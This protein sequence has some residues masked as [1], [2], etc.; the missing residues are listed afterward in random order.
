MFLR[1]LGAARILPAVHGFP[2]NLRGI[3]RQL[4]LK[5]CV[6]EPV[7]AVLR[8]N[9]FPVPLES[10]SSASSAKRL[11]VFASNPITS[12]GQTKV[13][14]T[15]WAWAVTQL[16]SLYWVGEITSNTVPRVVVINSWVLPGVA[17]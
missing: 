5:N 9:G 4:F 3:G 17:Q 13:G 16:Q 10:V 8:G 14:P 2:Q 7:K 15:G 11:S 1:Q 6:G 12:S